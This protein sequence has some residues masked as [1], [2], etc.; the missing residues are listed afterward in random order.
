MTIAD[1]TSERPVRLR[2]RADLVVVR[3]RFAGVDCRVVKDPLA[4]RYVRL[5]EEEYVLFDALDGRRSLRDLAL[6]FENRF[7]PR[8]ISVEEISRFV[9]MLHQNGLL[10]SDRSGQGPVLFRKAE[11]RRRNEWKARLLNPLAIRFRGVD[12]SRLLEGLYR[13]TR[14]LFN[15][16]AAAVSLGMMIAASAL[17]AVRWREFSSRLPS[18]YEFFSPENLLILSLVTAGV[19]VLHEFGHALACRHFGGECREMGAML[20][21]FTPCLYC[22][23]TDAWMFPGKW[24]RAAVG[25]AG[26][27]V[28]LNLA[29]LATFVWWF[30]APGP[31]NQACLGIMTV[32]SV[33]TLIFNGN[34]LMRYDGYYVLSDLAEAP[35]LAEQSAAVLR[36]Y[37]AKFLLGVE[38]PSGPPGPPHRRGRYA[39]YAACSGVYRWIVTFSILLFLVAAARPYRLDNAARFLGSLG[40]A[41]LILGPLVRLKRFADVPGGWGR[42]RPT[43]AVR[44]VV[45]GAL[46]VGLLL[47]P[48]PFRIF[49]PLEI[50]PFDAAAVYVEVPGRLTSAP[51]RYGST[52][53]PQTVVAQ[54]ENHDLELVVEQLR[55]E[56]D[57][58]IVE[59]DSLRRERF[60]DSGASAAVPRIE[61]L[62]ESIE[63]RL[64]KRTKELERLRIAATRGGVFFPPAETPPPEATETPVAWTGRPL[65]PI[66]GECS[67]DVGAV[68]GFVGDPHE[69]QAVVVV[70]QEDVEFLEVGCAADILVDAIP[71]TVFAGRVEEIALGE[72]LDAPRR[73]S[74][75]SGGDLSTKSDS[76]D[77]ERPTST[78]YQVRIRVSDPLARMRIGWRGTA[79]IHAPP[80]SLGARV[81]RSLSRTFHFQL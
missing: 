4:L 25:A 42:I 14:P 1:R 31:L 71:G 55:S 33:S 37:C 68:L 23:V 75:K 20:L 44:A 56:R 79:R 10:V 67:F 81:L 70:D 6:V 3:G 59:L 63:G 19:K 18:F 77:G 51:V 2:R 74:H 48:L 45:V 65:D 21:V 17:V 29:A 26:I 12:P 47:V 52:V 64:A 80:I 69:W 34:P 61:K 38:S 36:Y 13:A 73:L 11:R 22:D 76:G 27:F 16:T 28:E 60:D 49:A 66:N 9:L 72:L 78:S 32:A 7:P 8:R 30:S 58:R 41:M 57:R 5:R 50:Q 46:V 35:N 24:R 43:R 40:V 53:A 62:L 39:L 54:L 15:R